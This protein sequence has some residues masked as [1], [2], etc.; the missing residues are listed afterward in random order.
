MPKGDVMDKGA[1]APHAEGTPVDRQHPHTT[2]KGEVVGGD[3]GPKSTA[4]T[5]KPS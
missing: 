1:M 2:P 3:L 4:N 5:N